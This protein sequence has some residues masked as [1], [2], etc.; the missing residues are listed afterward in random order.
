MI[1][2][3]KTHPHTLLTILLMSK[4]KHIGN[5]Y[6]K[7]FTNTVH[8]ATHKTNISIHRETQN[9]HIFNI[10]FTTSQVQEAIK[11]SKNYNSQGPDKLNIRHLKLIGSL[12]LAV[13]TSMF[14]IALNNI[15]PDTWKLANIVPIPKPIQD[16]EKGTSYRHISLPSELQRHWRRAFFLT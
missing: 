12:G 9:I 14:K 16:T 15:I 10:T 8:H 4:Y 3:I 5:C 11:Q 1:P 7:Q 13:L 2:L 6:H